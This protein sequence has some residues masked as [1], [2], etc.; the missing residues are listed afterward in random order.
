MTLK[1]S[2]TQPKQL[3]HGMCRI[4]CFGASLING[5]LAWNPVQKRWPDLCLWCSQYNKMCFSSNVSLEKTV[6]V[7]LNKPPTLIWQ[8]FIA[9]ACCH[10][11]S[12]MKTQLLQRHAYS[13]TLHFQLINASRNWFLFRWGQKRDKYSNETCLSLEV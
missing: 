7:H 3:H 8:V 11:N 6:H 13:W 1:T 2:S 12:P 4:Q 9:A 5:W 10:R